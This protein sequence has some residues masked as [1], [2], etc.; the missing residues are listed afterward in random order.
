MKI[1]SILLE[2]AGLMIL[3]VVLFPVAAKAYEI[4]D[5][6]NVEEKGDFVLGPG[7]TEFFLEPG[8]KE[9]IDLLVTNRLGR[10]MDF[11]I[12]I[13][14]FRG[15]HDPNESTV[16]L[17]EEKGP[18]SLRDYLYPEIT[19]FTLEHGQRMILPVVISIP[20]DAEPGGLYGS[21]LVSNNPPRKELEAEKQTAKGQMR[22]ISRIGCLFF[23]RVKG[24]VLEEGFLKELRLG[25]LKEKKKF[26][27]KGPI[28]F[29]T[30]FKNQGNVH[31]NPY[32]KIEVVN[33]LGRKIDEVEV[34]P[35]FVMP[36]SERLSEVKW[37]REFLFGRYKALASINRGYGEGI[38]DQKSVVFWVL[39]WKIILAALAIIFLIVFS[40]RR[41]F[42]KF[43]IK[44]KDPKES[45][46]SSSQ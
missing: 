31:L 17:G 41:L 27:E 1:K 36:D 44:R 18:Y 34:K 10:T 45:Q 5:L 14:D 8:Q 3:I 12:G 2:L 9:K 11:K 23:V 7:K 42:G 29:V 19:E 13:E 35:F 25:K 43:E 46:T 20:E 15:S 37:N 40:I 22:L 26:Y 4:Q 16:L 28:S 38:I 39:P 21:V 30:V 32:G 24:N 6:T 33:L